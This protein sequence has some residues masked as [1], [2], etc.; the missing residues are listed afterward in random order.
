MEQVIQSDVELSRV[1]G[2]PFKKQ[3]VDNPNN[4]PVT[5]LSDET[6]SRSTDYEPGSVGLDVSRL[7]FCHSY[8]INKYRSYL[9][10]P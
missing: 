10:M 6:A 4:S 5:S 7:Y 8:F 2:V 3:L 1:F 9:I